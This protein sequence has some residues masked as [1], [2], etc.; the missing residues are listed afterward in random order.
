M[1]LN[2]QKRHN[3]KIKKYTKRLTCDVIPSTTNDM[4]KSLEIRKSPVKT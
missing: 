2:M 1:F 4:R 3:L